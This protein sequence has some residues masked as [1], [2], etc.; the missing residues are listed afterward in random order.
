MRLH[1][2]SP[3]NDAA[4]HADFND[5]PVNIFALDVGPDYAG[6]LRDIDVRTLRQVGEM[7]RN[8]TNPVPRPKP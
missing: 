2:P 7:I 3:R 1:P 6:K 5:A 4:D 8:G